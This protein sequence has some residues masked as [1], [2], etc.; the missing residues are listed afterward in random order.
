MVATNGDHQASV[1]W[2]APADDGHS[3]ITGYTVTSSPGGQDRHGRSARPRRPP[4]PGSTNGT[5][6]TFTVKATNA[7]GQGPA[8]APS[9]AVTPAALLSQTITFA[10]PANQ[11]LL[12][13]PLT[14]S[15][16]ASSG[17]TVT[18]TSTTTAVCTVTGFSI[19][20]LT[21]GTCSITAT[22]PGDA[23]YKAANPVTRSFTVSQ[24]SQTDHLRQA[25]QPDPAGLAPDGQRDRQLGPDRDPHLD[26]HARCAR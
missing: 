26:H 9:N 20:L 23:V 19:T 10:K 24:A 12:A 7:V 15:A 5:S 21:A 8:S 22:Q 14:V 13:S 16:T 2:T 1:T 3:P 6:Y 25:G 17:L 11:T 4:S 18:L